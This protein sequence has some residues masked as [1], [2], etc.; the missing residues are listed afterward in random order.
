MDKGNGTLRAYVARIRERSVSEICELFRRWVDPPEEARRVR[1][2]SPLES[3]LAVPGSG[4]LR[5]RLVPRDGPQVSGLAGCGEG[6]NRISKHGRLL[7][8]PGKAVLE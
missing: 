1:L 5:G 6:K 3:L 4:A 2:F 8:G 7:P